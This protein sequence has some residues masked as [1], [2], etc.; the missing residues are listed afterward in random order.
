MGELFIHFATAALGLCEEQCN[1]GAGPC[2]LICTMGLIRLAPPLVWN[3]TIVKKAKCDLQFYSSH[4]TLV[5]E[6]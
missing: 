5:T 1:G 6:T 2:F 3:G 4:K